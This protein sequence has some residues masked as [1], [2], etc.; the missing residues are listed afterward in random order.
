[1]QSQ[2]DTLK[3]DREQEQINFNEQID[4]LKSEYQKLKDDDELKL[5]ELQ[6]KSLIQI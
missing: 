2:V 1:M 5:Q 6:Q 3:K 4:Q